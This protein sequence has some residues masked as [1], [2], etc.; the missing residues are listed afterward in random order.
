MLE[1]LGM[2]NHLALLKYGIFYIRIA[3]CTHGSSISKMVFQDPVGKLQ[4]F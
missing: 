3:L 4:L 2:Q 1:Y